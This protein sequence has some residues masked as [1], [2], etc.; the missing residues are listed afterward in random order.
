MDLQ[1]NNVYATYPFLLQKHA[2]FFT[3]TLE[4]K[5][6]VILSV[7]ELTLPFICFI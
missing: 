4:P 1:P 2:N 3:T 7:Q 6:S 5:L